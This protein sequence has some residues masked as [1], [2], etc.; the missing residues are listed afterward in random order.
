MDGEPTEPTPLTPNAELAQRLL[1]RGFYLFDTP[2]RSSGTSGPRE[3]D[4]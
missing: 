3:A 1:E 4:D 2:R